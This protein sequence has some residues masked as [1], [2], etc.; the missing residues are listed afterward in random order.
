MTDC[1]PLTY[2]IDACL[3]AMGGTLGWTLC[4]WACRHN[5][6]T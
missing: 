2:L 4:L 3:V 6:K 5:H 1:S